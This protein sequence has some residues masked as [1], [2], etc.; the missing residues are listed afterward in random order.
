MHKD[1]WFML[2]SDMKEASAEA[3][4][5]ERHKKRHLGGIRFP[6]LLQNALEDFYNWEKGRRDTKKTRPEEG[7]CT[8]LIRRFGGNARRARYCSNGEDME[9]HLSCSGPFS[10]LLL[11]HSNK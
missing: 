5:L 8:T 10:I 2:I 3:N 6:L 7:L 1:Q 4:R 9:S 11:Q